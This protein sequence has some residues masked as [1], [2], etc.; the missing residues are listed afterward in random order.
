MMANKPLPCLSAKSFNLL[1]KDSGTTGSITWL[2][3]APLLPTGNCKTGNSPD[4]TSC[5]CLR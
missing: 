5:Q 1:A 3:L 4:K 2:P